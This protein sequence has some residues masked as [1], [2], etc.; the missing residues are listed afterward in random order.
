MFALTRKAWSEGASSEEEVFG[1]SE[2]GEEESAEDASSFPR[3]LIFVPLAIDLILL[4]ITFGH[5]LV[6]FL[7]GPPLWE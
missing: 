6:Y 4:P 1:A 2:S 5:D 7:L 3:V